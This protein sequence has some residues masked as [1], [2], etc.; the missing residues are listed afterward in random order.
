M[1]MNHKFWIGKRVLITGHTGFKGSWLSLW[2]QS[3]GAIVIGYAL[4]PQ[5][6]PNLFEIAD[7]PREMKCITGDI[8]DFKQLQEVFI[9]HKPEIVIH[10]AA[11]ALVR[12]AYDNPVETYRTNV[13][14]TVNLLEVVRCTNTTKV[15]INV[16]SDK[17][18]ENKEW[19][20]GYRE[21]DPMGGHDPYSSSKGCAELIT[22]AYRDSY[23]NA[24]S[25]PLKGVASARAG[26]VIG[27]GD[28]SQDRLIPD[29]VQA[30]MQNQPAIIRNPYAIRP[31]QHVLDCLS[32]YLYLAEKLW[33]EGEH[34][35]QAWNFGPREGE[36]KTVSWV[37]DRLSKLWG[38]NSSWQVDQGEHVHEAAYLKLD[39]SKAI[40]VLGWSPKLDLE[41]AL[42]W[43]VQWYRAYQAHDNMHKITKSQIID[44][45]TLK[46]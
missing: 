1:E 22:S 12:Q 25:H 29:I 31:W 44:Y 15:I 21:N 34:F 41:T 5:T 4:S 7:V 36:V 19:V 39:C 6:Q 45:M 42:S 2:L 14:G 43:V 23:F 13:M 17:C 28:W 30:M 46:K 10:M 8:C 32:G 24:R 38:C 37:A 16:T 35:S 40:N 33:N 20:W 11:Q 27:G 26:N 18:Y 3:L 9:Q